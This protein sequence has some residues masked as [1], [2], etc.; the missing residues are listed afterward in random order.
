MPDYD[1]EDDPTKPI[2]P[3]PQGS[4]EPGKLVLGNFQDPPRS[5][6]QPYKYWGNKPGGP[7]RA[8]QQPPQGNSGYPQ[9]PPPRQPGY[10]QNPPPVGRPGIQ[11]ANYGYQ[12]G[13]I[14]SSTRTPEK[15]QR[16]P[17]RR[18][19]CAIGCLSVLLI[20]VILGV[21]AFNTLQH[22]LAFGSA[23][24][25]KSPLS[26]ETSYMG[27]TDRTNLLVMGYGGSG[28]DGAFLTDS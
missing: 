8:P 3:R 15:L 11:D 17:R 20:L 22:V 27:T 9:N 1:Y 4:S 19:G 16:R 13:Q 14:R 12:A 21:V 6:R 10:P 7:Q 28:H 24:S 23:I 2:P 25:T 18:N 5:P 26:T